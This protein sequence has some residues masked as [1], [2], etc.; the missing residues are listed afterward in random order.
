[1]YAIRSYYD[2]L[3]VL[4]PLP[5]L[6]WGLVVE[7]DAAQAYQGLRQAALESAALG[8]GFALLAL[9]LGVLLGRR[10]AA[11]IVA[12]ARA[13]GRVAQGEFAV[14]VASGRRDEVGDM[15]GAFNRMAE[16]LGAYERNNFV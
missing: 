6:G 12:V 1:M 3:G 14:R 4:V 5:Q 16:S 13:A 9:A 2:L 10:M 7:Q 8:S 11:P 15:A